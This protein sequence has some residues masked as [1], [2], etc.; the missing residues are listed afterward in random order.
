MTD[1]DGDGIF[2]ISVELPG[3]PLSTNSRLTDG[4][5]RGIRARDVLY[6]YN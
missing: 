5:V 2:E 1:P 6:K 4:L 3:E